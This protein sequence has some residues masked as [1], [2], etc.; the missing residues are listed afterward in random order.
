[1]R[2]SRLNVTLYVAL[3]FASGLLVG[4]FGHRLY[5]VKTVIAKGPEEWRKQYMTE[6]QKRLSLRQEQVS[7]LNT[8]LDETRTRFHEVR[9]KSRPEMESI[10]S[11]QQAKI[12]AIL[13]EG[14][15]AEYEKMRQ[16]RDRN[17]QKKGHDGPGL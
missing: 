2:L 10:K 3:I 1:M 4:V 9:E 16:E 17:A 6:M 7:Q 5:M 15:R 12:R 14:Q 11:Q 13:D 8:V